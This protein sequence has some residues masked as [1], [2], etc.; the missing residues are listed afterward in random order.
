MPVIFADRME[1]KRQGFGLLRASDGFTYDGFWQNNAMEGRGTA[2]YPNGQTYNGLFV[3][4]RREGRG[5]LLFTNGAVYEG[6]FRDDAL[7]GQGT[8]KMPTTMTVPRQ[9]K[10]RKTE[11][12]PPEAKDEK[13]PVGDGQDG[14]ETTA[15]NEFPAKKDE[16]ESTEKK[17]ENANSVETEEEEEEELKPD[18]MIPL[19]FQSDMG[20]IHQK[21]GFTVVG[22]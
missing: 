3:D 15:D 16:E 20:Y 7:E 14:K 4:G 8:L 17:K 2:V 11:S 19:S 10:K 22:E 5:T 18:Y 12:E 1:F 9:K 21:A 13:S 6:R